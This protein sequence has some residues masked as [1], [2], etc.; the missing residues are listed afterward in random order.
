MRR[1]PVYIVCSPRPDVGKTLLA[2]LLTEFL[3]LQNGAVTAF[4]INLREPSLLDYL[5]ELTE[6]ALITDTFGQ[7]ALMDRLVLNDGVAKVIDLGFHAFDDFFRIAGEIGYMKEAERRGVEPILLFFA[8]N[9]RTS[10]R[11][12]SMLHKNFPRIAIVPVDND[13]VLRGALP[14][15]YA[16]SRPLKITALPAFLKTFIGRAN[17]S[18]TE[19]L[20][21]TLDQSSEL[22]KWVRTNYTNFRELEL[23]LILH[24]M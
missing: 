20:R 24:K 13:H 2:R 16:G 8:G 23:T 12:W 10:T 1:T 4:D 11:A 3:L 17:F 18:F 22:H 6:T 9:D 14:E 5:P 19:Y 7:M 15:I 21:S